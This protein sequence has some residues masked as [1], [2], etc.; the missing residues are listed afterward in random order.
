MTKL[1]PYSL[2]LGVGVG[3]MVLVALRHPP[4]AIFAAV[5]AIV[6]IDFGIKSRKPKV[7][8]DG[9]KKDD[10]DDKFQ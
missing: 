1:H 3:I 4:F 7:D 2:I 8:K 5:A 6:L 9:T 10:R